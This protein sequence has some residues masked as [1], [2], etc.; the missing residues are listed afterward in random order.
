M[1]KEDKKRILDGMIKDLN[2]V[3]EDPDADTTNF[4]KEMIRYGSREKIESILEEQKVF[5][6]AFEE[7]LDKLQKIRK[8]E[9]KVIECPN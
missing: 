6:R 4:N 7:E 2:A 5:L 3:Q 9:R 1:T 8:E